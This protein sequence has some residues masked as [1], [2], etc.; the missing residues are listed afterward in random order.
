M[1]PQAVFQKYLKMYTRERNKK[2][3]DSGVDD[4]TV[5]IEYATR[6]NTRIVVLMHANSRMQVR[7]QRHRWPR[8]AVV[9]TAAQ[10]SR[11]SRP[12]TYG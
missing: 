4:T 8:V 2:C 6:A 11:I 10:C 12:K 9:V 1:Q 7:L 5:Y 3:C